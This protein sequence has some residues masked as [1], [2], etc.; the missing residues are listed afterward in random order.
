MKAL[1]KTYPN[2]TNAEGTFA[3]LSSFDSNGFTLSTSD[4]NYNASGE[5][6]VAWCWKA[7]G[8]KSSKYRW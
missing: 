2:L 3:A 4:A 7:G 5:D 6:Y 1:T 8:I